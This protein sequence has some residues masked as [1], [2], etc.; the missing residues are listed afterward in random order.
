MKRTPEQQEGLWIV[1]PSDDDDGRFTIYRL[2]APGRSP[3]RM[4]YKM[5]KAN[6]ER[7]VACVNGCAGINP[8]AV[9]ETLALLKRAHDEL[10]YLLRGDLKVPV[11]KGLLGEI[12]SGIFKADQTKQGE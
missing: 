1:E 4:A 10:D 7:I 8:D 2:L 3:V 5:E 6:A 12:R 9:P 11:N